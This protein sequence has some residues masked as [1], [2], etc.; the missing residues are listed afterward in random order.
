MVRFEE[1]LRIKLDVK[2][3]EREMVFVNVCI[4]GRYVEIG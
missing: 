3:R 4:N 2:G 1:M